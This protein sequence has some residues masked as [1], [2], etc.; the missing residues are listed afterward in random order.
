MPYK[1]T[2]ASSDEVERM[3]A[4]VVDAWKN[5]DINKPM[6]GTASREE[7]IQFWTAIFKAGFCEPY[8]EYFK[9][10]DEDG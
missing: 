5:D 6:A 4:V 7:Q 3:M 2:K 9:V 8:H 1:L 10:V